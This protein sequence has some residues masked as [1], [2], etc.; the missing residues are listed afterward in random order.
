MAA[1]TVLLFV[2]NKV[3]DCLQ[4]VWYLNKDE[5]NE[6]VP[7]ITGPKAAGGTEAQ[8]G[9]PWPSNYQLNHSDF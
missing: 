5:M 2:L 4:S 3:F 7:L 9:L 1:T 8:N 6:D